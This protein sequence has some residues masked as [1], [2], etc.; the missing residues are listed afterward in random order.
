MSDLGLYLQSHFLTDA[1][2]AARCGIAR[3]E[4]RESDR[5]RSA[6]TNE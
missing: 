5:C 4:S 6:A 3:R 2:F 1:Q